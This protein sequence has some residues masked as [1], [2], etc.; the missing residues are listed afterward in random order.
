MR[1]RTA[2]NVLQAAGETA[3]FP[4]HAV[5]KILKFVQQLKRIGAAGCRGK[6]VK[7]KLGWGETG[8][9]KQRPWA[10]DRLGMFARRGGRAAGTQ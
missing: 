10:R 2:H 9:G 4:M 7:E 1:I 8:E 5:D 6:R 3:R